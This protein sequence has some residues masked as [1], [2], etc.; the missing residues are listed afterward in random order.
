ML[1]DG[2]RVQEFA[3]SAT[4]VRTIVES[5][6][7]RSLD[8]LFPALPVPTDHPVLEVSELSSPDNSFRDVTFDVKAGE[9][10]G[11][12]GLVGAGRTELVRAI[13]G[14]DPIGAGSIKLEGEELRLRDPADAIAK[15]IVMVPEDRKD[16]GSGGR[17]PDR[18]EHR[19]R[20]SRHVRVGVG[21]HRASSARSR[22]KAVAKFG[23]KGRAEQICFGPVRRQPAEGRHREMAHA[24]SQGRGPRTNP[25]EASTS[26]PGR[27]STRSSSI[28]RNRAWRSSSSARTSRRFSASQTAFCVLAQGK[29]AGILNR[30]E[31]ND[32][33]VMELATI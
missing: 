23:V 16:Q 11:I 25:R 5:M 19:L 17:A 2:E 13:S 12:A 30:D 9:I 31:A 27:A 6:V 14:A 1:R 18:R 32:V 20:Q 4:P 21:S 33:S 24:Q 8:R 10:L 28:L 7:G 29:Q 26:A 3:D 22:T 15:G